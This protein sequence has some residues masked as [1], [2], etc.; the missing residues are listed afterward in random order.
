MRVLEKENAQRK[1]AFFKWIQGFR[2]RRKDLEDVPH[3]AKSATSKNYE[4]NEAI[5]NLIEEDQR[6]SIVISYG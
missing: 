6:M 1:I 3:T 4:N 2:E 5:Q